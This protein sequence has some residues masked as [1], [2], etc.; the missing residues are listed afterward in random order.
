VSPVAAARLC[1]P[2]T[3]EEILRALECAAAARDPAMPPMPDGWSHSATV[4]EAGAVGG[5][6]GAAGQPEGDGRGSAGAAVA[7]ARGG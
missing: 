7:P 3:G 2:A 5:W 4:L 6:P 1:L